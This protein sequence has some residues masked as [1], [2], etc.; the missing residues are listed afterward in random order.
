MRVQPKLTSNPLVVIMHVRWVRRAQ[1]L[2]S[3]R[4]FFASY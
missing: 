3:L 4:S 2:L 1:A